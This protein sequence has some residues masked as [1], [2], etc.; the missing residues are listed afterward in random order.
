MHN[1]RWR[2]MLRS[3]TPGHTQ[4][5]MAEHTKNTYAGHTQLLMAGYAKKPYTRPCIIIDNGISSVPVKIHSDF[6]L[7]KFPGKGLGGSASQNL[8]F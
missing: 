7:I 1:Y 3:Y 2:D 6:L 8:N 5:L 4:L